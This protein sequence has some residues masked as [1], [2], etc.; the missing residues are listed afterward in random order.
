MKK[1]WTREFLIQ[2]SL[3]MK[4]W[5]PPLDLKFFYRIFPLSFF[6]RSHKKD[7]CGELSTLPI[8]PKHTLFYPSQ[9]TVSFISKLWSSK[10][11]TTRSIQRKWEVLYEDLNIRRVLIFQSKFAPGLKGLL[12]PK[13]KLQGEIL[14]EDP[15]ELMF[16]I[17]HSEHTK[18]LLS[19]ILSW[20]M[21]CFELMIKERG[22]LLVY[23]EQSEVETLG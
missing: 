21:K 17:R 22:Y 19:I 8:S 7:L 13:F 6:S 15:H 18:V 9:N 2:I 5:T 16:K 1:N 10:Y 14:W 11:W 4:L 12:Q 20:I 3:K 23:E